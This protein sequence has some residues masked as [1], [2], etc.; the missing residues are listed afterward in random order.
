VKILHIIDSGGLY[1]AEIMLLNLAREQM[2]Q[3]HQ[4][5]I[6]SIGTPGERRKPIETA[7]ADMAIPVRVFRMRPGPNLAG[8]RRILR[9]ARKYGAEIL[10]SHGYK[11]DILF[12]LMPRR[13]RGIP[14]VTTLHG[15]TSTD[16]FSLLRLYEMADRIAL[17]N[18]DG[19]VM[20]SRSMALPRGLKKRLGR[21]LQVIDNGIEEKIPLA[22]KEIRRDLLDFC[23]RKPTIGAIGRLSPEKGF[24]QLIR[25]FRILLRQ[26]L[27]IQL[28]ILG[29]GEE[30][31]RL[32]ELTATT[33][34]GKERILLPGFIGSA[35]QY[36]PY[37]DL[38]A[39]PSLTEGLPITLLEAMRARTAVVASAVGGIPDIVRNDV[40]AL[41][42]P[43]QDPEALAASLGR[44]LGDKVLTGRL[45]E[46]AHQDFLKRYTSR[47]MAN[48]YTELYRQACSA[49]NKKR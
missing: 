26:G 30:R 29:E 16:S 32:E 31:D 40:S 45:T 39:M 9:Y 17:G 37:F 18:V 22:D 38:L 13:I 8:G 11:G 12:G 21:R 3:G 34:E 25:A 7:A 27:D 2:A 49:G 5:V 44:L 35:S 28:I 42:V 10:H 1:G 6:A 24:D 33:P 23:S 15:W 36:M 48:R 14:L 43:P 47:R 46:H 19:V 4:V 20:V 41:L